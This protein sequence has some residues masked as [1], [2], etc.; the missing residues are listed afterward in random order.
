MKC[1]VLPKQR[2]LTFEDRPIPEPG[3]HH[4]LIK[5][6][7]V[8]VC[9]SDAHYYTEGRI[10]DFV[11][12]SPIILGHE[13]A[14]V[15]AAVGAQVKTLKQGD[16]VTFEPGY[17]CRRC[18]YC[19]SGA[20]NLCPQVT[21]M[22]TPPVDGCFCEFVS[23]PEDF[24]F[25]LP[26]S[27]TMEDG[28]TMEPASCGLWA[29]K[30]GGVKTGDSVVVFG[31]GPIGLLTMQAAKVAGATTLIAVDIE[32]FR[33]EYARRLGA[34]HVFNDTDGAALERIR[35]LTG[36]VRGF[37]TRHAGADVT[38][39]TAGTIPTVRNTLAAVRPGGV[40]VLVGLPPDPMVELDIVGAA[41]KE[42]DIRGMFRYVNQYPAAIAL[43]AGGRID[44]RRLVTHHYPLEK[45]EDALLFV[46]TRKSESIK[47]MIDVAE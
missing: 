17:T 25:H 42:I 21:F 2:V 16:R 8:G 38:F 10:G 3:P 5:I 24:V 41:S 36:R 37:G 13:G 46:H 39:E 45:V 34:T 29:V 22:G 12:N 28:A 19:K 6:L 14:G 1:A 40:A 20:Y 4:V 18:Y 27:M 30:R 47:V 35:K 33:L 26:D 7:R 44:V 15:V 11:V 43:A 32:D 23:W 9:G 31:V